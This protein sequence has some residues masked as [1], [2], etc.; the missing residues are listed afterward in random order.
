[1]DMLGIHL[2]WCMQKNHLL[3]FSS[4]LDIWENVEWPRFFWT[5]L[6]IACTVNSMPLLKLAWK[7]VDFLCHFWWPNVTKLISQN[8]ELYIF[9]WTGRQK[10][11][12]LHRFAPFFSKIFWEWHPRNWGG[13]AFPRLLLLGVLPPSHV[14]RTS[15]HV[16]YAHKLSVP[17]T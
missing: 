7:K 1:M 12:K 10:C 3:I 16:S 15:P 13:A 4:F 2:P 9:C 17:H 5:T 6:Y 8:T 14:F 11:T